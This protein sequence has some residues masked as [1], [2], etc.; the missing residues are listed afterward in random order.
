MGDQPPALADLV[1]Y[2]TRWSAEHA[3][4]GPVT[5]RAGRLAYAQERPGYR[6]QHGVLWMRAPLRRGQGRPEFGKLHPRR[7]RA[8]MTRLWCQVCG[9]AASRTGEGLLWLTGEDPH[10]QG[11]WPDPLETADPPLCAPCAVKAVQM[12]PMLRR[13]HTALRVQ[14]VSPVAVRGSLYQPWHPDP[15]PAAAAA[16]YLDDPRANWMLAG[17]LIVALEQY[18]ITTLDTR[19][20]ATARTG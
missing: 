15:I 12:C 6:D 10:D 1:P 8:A 17:Q 20:P 13:R 14:R 16:V 2:I 19:H 5:V 3:P 4:A 11:T 9:Q 7:Q 18:T